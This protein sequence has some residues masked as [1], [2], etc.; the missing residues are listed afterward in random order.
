MKFTYNWLKQYVDFDWSPQQLAEKLTDANTPRF[1]SSFG[2]AHSTDHRGMDDLIRAA[3]IA[4]YYAKD[5]GRDQVIISNPAQPTRTPERRLME[6]IATEF[7]GV[8]SVS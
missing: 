7:E 8:P 3:D 2:V 5:H 1:T 4:L 6:A